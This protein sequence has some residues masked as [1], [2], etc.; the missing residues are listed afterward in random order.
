MKLKDTL[1]IIATVLEMPR[2]RLRRLDL[3]AATDAQRA[4]CEQLRNLAMKHKVG[5]SS[6]YMDQCAKVLRAVAK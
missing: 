2:D 3:G 5:G 6:D 1:K 4:A